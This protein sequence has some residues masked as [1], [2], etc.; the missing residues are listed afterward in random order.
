MGITRIL[1]D[2]AF[3]QTIIFHVK[4]NAVKSFWTQEFSSWN[5]QYSSQAIVPILNKVGQFISNP[6]IR[7]MVGQK[8]NLLD[9]SSFMNKGKIVII[10]L[11]KGKIGEENSSLLGSMF[12]TKIQQAALARAAM[13]EDERRDFYL[14]I[15]EFQNFAT[16]AFESIL[17]EAR[18]Y[19]LN[20]TIA[21]Q[22]IDQLSEE[23]RSAVFGNVGNVISFAV[24]SHDAAFLANE[25]APIFSADDIINLE[26]R[27]MYLK[28]SVN[29]TLTRPFS[30][31]TIT[32]HKNSF[33]YALDI[34]SDSRAHYG[35]NRIAV[36]RT[37]EKW[38][39]TKNYQQSHPDSEGDYP[40]PI[41]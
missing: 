25:F 4:D 16:E 26:V 34:V 23:V 9:F 29:G 35:R 32:T 33:D 20:L 6:L 28:L 39:K 18:K 37:I 24:G 1:S 8:E 14:Y 36:E 17:S 30:A 27:E 19:H 10:N 7:N 12:I 13:P 22:Y 3:R 38:M 21:H 11:S 41:I 15:D 31:R 2:A 40:E 5:E